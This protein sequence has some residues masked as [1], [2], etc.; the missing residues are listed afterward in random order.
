MC[1]ARIRL[2]EGVLMWGMGDGGWLLFGS[3]SLLRGFGGCFFTDTEGEERERRGSRDG[4]F[5]GVL[6][7]RMLRLY[8]VF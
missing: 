8:Y 1:L 4:S 5:D 2:G 7:C 3:R 6:T